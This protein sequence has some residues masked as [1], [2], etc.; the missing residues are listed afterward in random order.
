MAAVTTTW[1]LAYLTEARR[2]EFHQTLA[3]VSRERPVAWVIGEAPNVVR[4]LGA[5]DAPFD[6]QGMEASVLG[7]VTFRDGK[8]DAEVLGFVH[9]HGSWIDWRA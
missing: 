9:P 6:E 5:V 8:A 4:A 2:D 3:E 7:L 1:A